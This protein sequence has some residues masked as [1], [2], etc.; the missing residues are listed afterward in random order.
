MHRDVIYPSYVIM[1]LVEY[2]ELKFLI[3]KH[4]IKIIL[5]HR[6]LYTLI[7]QHYLCTNIYSSLYIS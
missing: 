6:E 1:V 3:C 2:T 5:N 4:C 7:V